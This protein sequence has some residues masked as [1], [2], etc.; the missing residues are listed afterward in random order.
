M[1]TDF[2]LVNRRLLRA[3]RIHCEEANSSII[4]YI[5]NVYGCHAGLEVLGTV[6]L[7]AVERSIAMASDRLVGGRPK[8]QQTVS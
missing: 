8:P 7:G 6:L 5:D 2:V 4:S 1:T 3:G